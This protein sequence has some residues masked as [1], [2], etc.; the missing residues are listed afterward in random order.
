MLYAGTPEWYID[1]CK[2]IKYLFPKGHAVA[3]VTM[4][5]RIGYFKVYYPYSFYAASFSVKAEDFNYETMCQG[6]DTAKEAI[7]QI[8]ALGKEASATDK[9]MLTI[10]ELVVEMYA[11]GLKFATLDLYQAQAS[12]FLVTPEGLMPPL[13]SIQGLGL[14]VAQNIVSTRDEGPFF[15]IQEFRERTKT[16]KTVIELLKKIGILAGIPETNQLT[17]F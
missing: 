11:R 8:G 14:S 10:L 16:N 1:S 4:T 5:V 2:K 3:Y 6:I 17:L 13:C 12:K 15:T 9:S 7:A